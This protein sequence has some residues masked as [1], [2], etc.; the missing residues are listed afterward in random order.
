MVVASP[1]IINAL[2]GTT[3]QNKVF[4]LYAGSGHGVRSQT[5]KATNPGREK[6]ETFTF[7][8]LYL[9]L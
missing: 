3:R 6:A 1:A 4:V 5:Q 8:G 2:S 7:D 9:F